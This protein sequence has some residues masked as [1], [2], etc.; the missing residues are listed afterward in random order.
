[1][2]AL[3]YHTLHTNKSAHIVF[4]TGKS[5][6]ENKKKAHIPFTVHIYDKIERI[7]NSLFLSISIFN[8]CFILLSAYL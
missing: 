1:M 6:Q 3:K 5:Y 2:Y 4:L 7:L 8:L